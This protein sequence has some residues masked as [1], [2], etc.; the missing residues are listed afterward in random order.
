MGWSPPNQPP[1]S[2]PPRED[3]GIGQRTQSLGWLTGAGTSGRAPRGG[4]WV[5]IGDHSEVGARIFTDRLF[6]TGAETRPT[7]L[8]GKP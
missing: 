7:P 6:T 4:D 1:P 2:N 8:R 5:P 3:R